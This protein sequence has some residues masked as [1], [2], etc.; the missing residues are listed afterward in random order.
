MMSEAYGLS[1]VAVLAALSFGI[2]RAAVAR[3]TAL[4]AVG[5]IGV[6]FVGYVVGHMTPSANGWDRAG[7][8]R[9]P[10]Q[11]AGSAGGE[12]VSLAAPS[13]GRGLIVKN[14][15]KISIDI[16]DAA[17][18]G[19]P[20]NRDTVDLPKGALLQIAGWAA[21]AEADVPCKAVYLEID[22][23][24][25]DV[26]YGQPRRDVAAYYH[27]SAYA[28]TGYRAQIPTN[29]LSKG[30]YAVKVECLSADGKTLFVL[31][32]ARALVIE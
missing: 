30:S 25:F 5:F 12:T 10:A 3:P 26:P 21:D 15:S 27:N 6:F 2:L 24:R 11:W 31:N 14:G 1:L 28:V 29:R 19:T 9:T 17:N 4:L 13:L 32:R 20:G 7:Q 8:V 22:K 18:A 23:L 16:L